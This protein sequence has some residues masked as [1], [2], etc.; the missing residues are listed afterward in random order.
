[1]KKTK[2]VAGEETA[3]EALIGIG[4]GIIERADYIIKDLDGVRSI[5][6]HAEIEGGKVIS[7]DINKNYLVL[8][9]DDSDE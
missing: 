9:E 6:I 2:V 4:K 1:M 3:R 7:F 5:T 8:F